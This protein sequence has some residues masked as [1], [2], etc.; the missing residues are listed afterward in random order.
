MDYETIRIIQGYAYWFI[1]LLLVILLYTYV[2]H[3]YK[4]QK[5]GKIDYEKYARLAL[6][7]NLEDNLIEI[8]NKKEG[9][10]ES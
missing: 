10:K 2:Y 4:S 3:L 8:R 9:K 1:T 7:D 6:D 5:S